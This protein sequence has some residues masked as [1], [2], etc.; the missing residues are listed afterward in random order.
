MTYDHNYCP[1]CKQ[2]F[3]VCRKS[4]HKICGPVYCDEGHLLPAKFWDE[5]CPI[6]LAIDILHYWVGII[7]AGVLD[8]L[9]SL[10]DEQEVVRVGI[11]KE[12]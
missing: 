3:C 5:K 7:P 8:A 6:C 11:G 9:D 12:E 4:V 1:V 10:A 2:P